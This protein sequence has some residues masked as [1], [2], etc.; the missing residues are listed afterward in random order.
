MEESRPVIWVYQDQS[1]LPKRLLV[2]VLRSW[3]APAKAMAMPWLPD[4][5]GGLQKL[6]VWEASSRHLAVH[7]A[8]C[9]KQ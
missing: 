5:C 4:A 7:V 8:F 9:R 1:Y 2:S 6:K 3:A